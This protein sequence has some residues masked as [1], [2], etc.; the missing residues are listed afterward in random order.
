MLNMRKEREKY[1]L[2]FVIYP[3]HPIIYPSHFVIYLSYSVFCPSHPIIYPPHP[4]IYPS[5]FVMYLIFWS[6][7]ISISFPCGHY[8]FVKVTWANLPPIGSG[9][10]RSKTPMLSRPRNPP[11]KMFFPSGSLR[12]THLQI[13]CGLK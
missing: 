9:L 7:H 1:L 4:V 3:S 6:I 10:E 8:H 5:H 11:S 2:H 12:F 13:L